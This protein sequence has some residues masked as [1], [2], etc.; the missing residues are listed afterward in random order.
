MDWRK[1]ASFFATFLSNFRAFSFC[2]VC[3]KLL[4]VFQYDRLGTKENVA[5]AL[6]GHSSL[7]QQKLVFEKPA[8]KW[9]LFL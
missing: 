7:S 9:P 8:S 1:W 6:W 4:F 5:V 3:K 2:V